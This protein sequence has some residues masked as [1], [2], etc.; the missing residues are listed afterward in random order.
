MYRYQCPVCKISSAPYATRRSAERHGAGHRRKAHFG[1]HPIGE[2]IVRVPY[3]G[4]RG[5][6]WRVIAITAALIAIA[7]IV[8]AL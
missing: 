1:D 8:K 6:E 5:S 4:P 2:R 3:R 7:L